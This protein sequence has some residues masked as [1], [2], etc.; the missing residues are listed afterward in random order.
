MGLPSLAVTAFLWVIIIWILYKC[1]FVEWA[2]ELL[3]VGLFFLLP[4]ACWFT[5]GLIVVQGIFFPFTVTVTDQQKY[6]FRNGIRFRNLDLSPEDW[7][8]VINSTYSRGDWGYIV[9]FEKKDSILRH[10]PF[11]LTPLFPG[12]TFGSKNAARKE[13]EK[14][15]EKLQQWLSLYAIEMKDE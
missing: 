15:K 10:L 1:L 2:L 5:F 6:R 9:Y 3:V 4:G 8:V 11:C 13:A 14:V 7:R 12:S